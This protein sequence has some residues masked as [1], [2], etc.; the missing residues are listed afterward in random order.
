[1]KKFNILFL[2]DPKNAE[3]IF[4]EEEDFDDYEE[5]ENIEENDSDKNN[6]NIEEKE[7]EKYEEEEEKKKEEYEIYDKDKD[8]TDKNIEIKEYIN[9]EQILNNDIIKDILEIKENKE[10]IVEYYNKLL[11]DSKTYFERLEKFLKS[12]NLI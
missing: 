5:E 7:K 2:D 6:N 8:E 11:D 9:F 1:M 3:T 12:Y 4:Y 10:N